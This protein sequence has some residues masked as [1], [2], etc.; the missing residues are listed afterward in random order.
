MPTS[1]WIL[2]KYWQHFSVLQEWARSHPGKNCA[3]PI[4]LYGDDAKFSNTYLDKFTALALQ[5]PLVWKQGFLRWVNCQSFCILP[6]NVIIKGTLFWKRLTKS[7][8]STQPGAAWKSNFL[9]FIVETGILVGAGGKDSGLSNYEPPLIPNNVP[10]P[11]GTW[12]RK[13][14]LLSET[15][16]VSCVCM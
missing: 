6:P 3:L 2:R 14:P 1:F 16:C 4:A 8:A 15:G 7:I 13:V 11:R 10:L 5:S 9:F 12:C